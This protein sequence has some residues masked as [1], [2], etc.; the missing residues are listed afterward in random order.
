M[1]IIYHH[2]TTKRPVIF[3]ANLTA[4]HLTSYPVKGRDGSMKGFIIKTLHHEVEISIEEI[5]HLKTISGMYIGLSAMPVDELINAETIQEKM[6]PKETRV[7]RMRR[8]R[9]ERSKYQS[10]HRR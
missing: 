1:K 5:H 8:L 2:E 9:K 6:K 10:L 4:P 7:E 3:E